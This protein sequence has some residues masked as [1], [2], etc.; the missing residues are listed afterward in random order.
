MDFDVD[1]N[2]VRYR[3]QHGAVM[4]CVAMVAGAVGVL[5][6]WDHGVRWWIDVGSLALI[7]L[8]A[9]VCAATS[10][11]G[12]RMQRVTWFSLSVCIVSWLVAAAFMVL[13][14]VMWGLIDIPPSGMVD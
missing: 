2:E 9:P 8:V 11:Y 4:A 12:K 6:S 13:F 10:V 7:V 1:G 14:I 3:H 5:V